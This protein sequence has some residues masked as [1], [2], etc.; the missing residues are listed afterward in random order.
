MCVHERLSGFAA[1]A[2]VNCVL[3][4][5]GN[6]MSGYVGPRHHVSLAGSVLARLAVDWSE[7]HV[8]LAALISSHYVDPAYPLSPLCTCA[9]SPA[10]PVCKVELRSA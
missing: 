6:S 1:V 5:I 10:A 9:S 8:E 4:V 3:G 7:L 2:V